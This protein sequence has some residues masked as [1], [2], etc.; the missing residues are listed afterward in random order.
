MRLCRFCFFGIFLP[1]TLLCIPLYMRFVSLRPHMFTL[2]PLDMKLLNHEHTVSTIWCSAQQIKMN[3]TFNAYLLPEKPKL[4]RK[5]H[6]VQMERKIVD[7]EDDMK[8]YW[9]F[10]LLADSYFR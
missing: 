2:S 7:L 6:K 4:L 3:S 10:F 1:I 5:R 8:E 9:G